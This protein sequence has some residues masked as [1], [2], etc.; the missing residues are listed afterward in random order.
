MV[1]AF[2]IQYKFLT[3]DSIKHSSYT[4]QKLFRALYGY[5]QNVSK[6][7]GKSYKYHRSG[8]L[9]KGPYIRPGKNCVIISKDQLS[10]LFDFF[11][12]G[13]NPTHKWVGKG[14]W[15]AVYYMNEKEVPVTELIKPLESLLDRTYI[16]LSG[17][18]PHRLEQ[19]LA[20]LFASTGQSTKKTSEAYRKSLLEAANRL[21][22]NDWF[23]L[24]SSKSARLK[25]FH[26][27]VSRLRRA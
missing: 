11:K 26:A 16:S 8:V 27:L 7:N 22:T 13:R 15:K 17:E 19:A 9:S 4:Y 20:N 3:P 21:T 14:D 5:T 1:K 23:T 2:F 25:N 18:S 12:T 6:S 24:S 10:P